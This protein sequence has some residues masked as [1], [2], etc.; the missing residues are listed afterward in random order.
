M[1]KW[2]AP[3]DGGCLPILSYTV[4]KNGVDLTNV[5]DP[6]QTTFTDIISSGGA[7]GSNITYAIKANN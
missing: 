3:L 5:I 1:L 7:I 2:V 6:S 4:Q